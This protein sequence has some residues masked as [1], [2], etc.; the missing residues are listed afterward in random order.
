MSEPL[1]R[2]EELFAGF[3]AELR[4]EL[5]AGAD[6]F[7]AHT[8]LGD[9]IDGMAGRFEELEATMDRYGITRC[10]IFCL[11]EPDRHPGFRAGNDRTLEFAARS[12]GRMI[13]YVRLDLAEDPIEEAERWHDA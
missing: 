13:P 9:D 4:V 8:H 11:D 7:D 3:E 6:I 10:N 5:P 1:E 12:N 2:A